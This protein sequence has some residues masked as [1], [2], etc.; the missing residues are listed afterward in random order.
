MPGRLIAMTLLIC[1][2][3]GS[4][5][6]TI[7]FCLDNSAPPLGLAAIRMALAAAALWLWMGMRR[8]TA[9]TW[10]T[11][12]VVI[13]AAGFYCL[14]LA[15]THI[16]FNHTSAARGIVLLNTTPLFVAVLA[17]FVA[18]REPLEF[19][20]LSGLVLAFL[21]VVIIFARRLDGGG[22]LLGDG[23]M[24]LAAASWAFQ[25]LWM[26]RAAR[27]AD[28]TMLNS[29]QF[30][31]ALGVL[32]AISLATEP[33]TLWHPTAPVAL[34]IVYLAIAGT[35]VAWILWSRVLKQVPASTASAYI[36]TVPLFG[37]A[38]SWLLLGEPVTL[39][40]AMGAVLVS[41]GIV[42]VN[43][44][45]ALRERLQAWLTASAMRRAIIPCRAE[46]STRAHDLKPAGVGVKDHF[47]PRSRA[48]SHKWTF[49]ANR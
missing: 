45:S 18:P 12:R 15:F 28:P 2:L 33:V 46:P 8:T 39:Q 13:G 27:E 17:N 37:V 42:I 43:R 38:L 5:G 26:K 11:W 24:L 44:G 31:A 21:G 20:K 41:A 6:V 14:L 48:M 36:F 7:K 9:L 23:I 19:T 40:F 32:G 49:P 4:V 1:I 35:V 3:W 34:A 16:G 25:T 10:A 22:S 30:I 29:V 47:G